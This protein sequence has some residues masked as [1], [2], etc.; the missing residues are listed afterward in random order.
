MDMFLQTKITIIVAT[1]YIF[2]V[3]GVKNAFV[4]GDLPPTTLEE[5][6]AFSQTP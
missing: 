6:R 4:A 5:L 3:A 1:R 2:W